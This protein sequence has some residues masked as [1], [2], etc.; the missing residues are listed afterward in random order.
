VAAAIQ[1]H[2]RRRFPTGLIAR[3]AVINVFLVIIV[4]P[5][6]WVLLM[7]VKSLPESYSTNFWPR[8]FDFSHYGFV[9]TRIQTLPQ[10]MFNSI[11]VTLATVA[12]TTF[13]AI[14][15]GYTLVHVKLPGRMLLIWLL[16]A[17]LFFPTRLLSLISIYEIQR[18][19]GLL[20]TVVGLIF[21]YVTLNLAVSIL[22]M[23]GIFEQLPHE[24]VE[25]SRMDGCGPWRTLFLVLLPLLLN[26]IVVVS[27]VNFVGVWGEYLL[28]VTLTN[29]QATRTLP[30]VLASAHSGMG[31]WAYPRIAAVYVI[32]VTPGIIIFALFQRLYFKGLTEGAIKL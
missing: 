19:L 6:I 1:R 13:C 9:L 23:R 2:H 3:H 32:A 10:N 29:D 12:I 24:L 20:N 8:Q 11:F 16:I 31:Q 18:Q 15:G 27:M 30:V 5:L 17:S 21:P 14:L 28:A 4:L 26:G 22:I 25:A 7:S